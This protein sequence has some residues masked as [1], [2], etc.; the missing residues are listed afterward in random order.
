MTRAANANEAT[1]TQSAGPTPKA[2][3]SRPAAG[4]PSR[5]PTCSA[6]VNRAF[7]R[8]RRYP[9]ASAAAGT[10]LCRAAEPAASASVPRTVSST[11]CQISSASSASRTGSGAT[12]SPLRR[13]ATEL[14]RTG[15][16]A[17]TTRPAARPPTVA[18]ATPAKTTR[19]GD[20]GA[21]RRGQHQPRDGDRHEDVAGHRDRVAHDQQGQRG[22]PRRR[23]RVSSRG[24]A[25][26]PPSARGRG[27][28][29]GRS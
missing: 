26:C 15:P 21:T 1:V 22:G 19:P 17:S 8:S 28:C 11:T 6:E 20:G 23:W 10:R 5:Y 2:A 3:M 7:A 18:L 24:R 27:V 9:P 25:G 4:A 13:S 16:I 29:R 14:A 12:A